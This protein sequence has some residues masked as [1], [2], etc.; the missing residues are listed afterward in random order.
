MSTSAGGHECTNSSPR[1]RGKPDSLRARLTEIGQVACIYIWWRSNRSHTCSFGGRWR[2]QA[3]CRPCLSIEPSRAPSA[4]SWPLAAN[5]RQH[6]SPRGPQTVCSPPSRG[7]AGSLPLCRGSGFLKSSTSGVP[8]TPRH[9]GMC[10]APLA[11]I[12]RDGKKRAPAARR[13][14]LAR[15]A[16]Q[17]AWRASRRVRAS[18]LGARPH[19]GAGS[20]ERGQEQGEGRARAG[21]RFAPHEPGLRDSTRRSS[22]RAAEREL[23]GSGE[24]ERRSQAGG[25]DLVLVGS[26]AH[27]A[28]GRVLVGNQE[29]GHRADGQSGLERRRRHVTGDARVR[30][31]LAPACG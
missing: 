27:E 23:R 10:A 19:A 7:F 1:L 6:L 8:S 9:R 16:A 28:S 22:P 2:F 12:E 3:D 24:E 14:L 5:G 13:R 26:K 18:G 11:R 15:G 31:R 29:P 20:S 21:A 4:F 17:V 30:G 25:T